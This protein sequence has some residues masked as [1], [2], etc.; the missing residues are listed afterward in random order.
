MYP[1]FVIKCEKLEKKSNEGPETESF[2]SISK[3]ESP[4]TPY[5]VA[6]ERESGGDAS[7]LKVVASQRWLSRALWWEKW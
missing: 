7:R 1:T 6:S 2:E 5:S 4:E 3:R